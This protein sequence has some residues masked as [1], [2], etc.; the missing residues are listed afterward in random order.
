MIKIFAFLQVFKQHFCKFKRLYS[1]S[2]IIFQKSNQMNVTIRLPEHIGEFYAKQYGKTTPGTVIAAEGFYEI[3]RRTLRELQGKFTKPEI[4]ALVDNL[5]STLLDAQF[6]V[7]PE[8]LWASLED[9]GHLDGLFEKWGV[10]AAYFEK[11]ILALTAAQCFVL[12]DEIKAAWNN[13]DTATINDTE[14]KFSS[15]IKKLVL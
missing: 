14:Q 6:Q 2:N 12:Q 10:D 9:G 4:M 8:M 13:E 11:K 5:N 15:L 7:R 1:V 3:H